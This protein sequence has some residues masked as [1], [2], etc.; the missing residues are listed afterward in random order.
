MVSGRARDDDHGMTIRLAFAFTLLVTGALGTI[1]GCDSEAG[2]PA[3]VDSPLRSPET[4]MSWRQP[5][6]AQV[7][8]PSATPAPA[9]LPTATSTATVVS[10]MGTVI[11]GWFSIIWNGEA[12]FF[13]DDDSGTTYEVELDEDVARPRGGPLELN[14]KRLTI[15]GVFVSE[16]P[17]V[18]KAEGI[19]LAAD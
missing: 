5:T 2:D 13:I 3:T 16:E 19:E 18:F 11:T 17:K 8:T 6:S 9:A 14:R 12:R 4:P 15:T 10:E 7:P 1:Q